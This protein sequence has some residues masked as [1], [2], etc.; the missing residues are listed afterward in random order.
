MDMATPE[1]IQRV[2]DLRMVAK[3]GGLH[4]D[5]VASEFGFNSGDE[6]VRAI[7]AAPTPSE[8]IETLTNQRMLEKYGDINSPEALQRATDEAV[9]NKLRAKM[10]ATE[11]NA[12]VKAMNP[13]VDTGKT[14]AKGRRVTEG[15]LP[16]AAK[17]FAEQIISRKRVRDVKPAQFIASE[18]RAAKA[19]EKAASL[20]DKINEKKNQLINHYAAKAAQDALNDVEKSVKY[21]NRITKPA[22]LKNMRGEPRAQMLAILDR[23]DIRKSVT[24]KEL[25]RQQ[26]LADWSASEAERLAAPPPILSEAVAN[27]TVR[28][29]YKNLTVEEFRGLVDSIKQL[30]HLAR[31]EH[32]AYITIRNMTLQEEV[33][34]AVAEIREAYPEAFDDE[35][36]AKMETPLTHRYAPSFAKNLSKALRH[37]N[38]EFVPMEELVDQLTAGKF[39][40]LH[41]SLF[42]RLSDASDRKSIMAGEIRDRLKPAFKAYSLKEKHDFP[43]KVVANGMTRENI[44]MI[45]L[46]Y[47]NVEGRQRL[48]S[49]GFGD[50]QVLPLLSNLTAK[51]LDLAEAIW[52]LNDDYIWPM[53]AALNERT[54]GKAPAKVQALPMTIGTREVKGGYVKL[55]YDSTFDETTRHRDSMDDAMAMIG[56]RASTSAKTEQG[57]SN[58]R[59]AELSRMPLLE[60]RAMSQAVNEHMHDIAY[61]EAVADTVRVLRMPAMRDAIKVVSGNEVY[62]ELLAKVNEVAARPMNPTGIVL[63]TLDL[64]RRNTIVVLMSGVKTALVNYSGL[65]PAMNRVNGFALAKNMAKVH[66][67]RM[68]EMVRFAMENSIYMRERNQQFT[69]DLQHEMAS[70]TV[71]NQLLPTM[72]TFLI[73]MRTVDQI[74]STTV[75]TTAYEEGIREFADHDRAVEYANNITR[76]TQASGRDVDTSKIMTRFGPWSKPFLMFYSFFNRQLALLVRQ[77]VIAERAWANGDRAKAVGIFA[78]AYISVVVIPALINDMATGKCDDAFED[79]E[80]WGKCIGKAVSMNMAGYVPVLRDV[81]PYAWAKLDDSEPDWGLRTTALSAYF[82][83]VIKGAASTVNVIEGDY[84]EKDTKAIFMGLAFSFG[85]PGKLMWDV[86]AGTEAVV[87]GDAPPQSILFGPPKKH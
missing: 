30:E 7:A 47:G 11:L 17:Q 35:G 74:T 81:A 55:V 24:L 3:T 34:N 57:S 69:S 77:G 4:P 37:M 8:A 85:L 72:S 40:L 6:L 87:D 60:L 79:G 84:N 26:S 27:E 48:A 18:V 19:A 68:R 83:G 32:K 56:G 25:D 2:K 52:S 61:R 10:I 54:Q 22:A 16:Q 86:T 73:L 46:H 28:T 14:D 58:E 78:A 20:A 15:F 62:T 82:E 9:H 67:W 23:F 13:R 63:K 71:K 33:A 43:R 39:G 75:W 76:S 53:Y 59:I 65:I 41:D 66:S 70:L 29:H 42:G 49:Q 12:L 21:M 1:A 38:A 31:R 80:G 64:A 50:Q 44:L 51:D 45:A 5:L 36:K